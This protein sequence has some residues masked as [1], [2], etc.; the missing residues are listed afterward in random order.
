M[1]FFI[2]P[3]WVIAGL[4]LLNLITPEACFL[5]WLAYVPI[6]STRYDSVCGRLNFN[7][8][9]FLSLPFAICGEIL[10]CLGVIKRPR[11]L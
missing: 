2:Y 8:N 7:R 1:S 10:W 3:P 4:T 5:F 9:D 6:V 11:N